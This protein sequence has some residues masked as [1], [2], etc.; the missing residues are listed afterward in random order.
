[1]TNDFNVSGNFNT[2]E[3]EVSV[4]KRL[5]ALN[6]VKVQSITKHKDANAG[7]V[8]V[9]LEDGTR[10]VIEVK[11][12]KFERFQ[13]YGDLG[14]DLLS[15]FQFKRPE[16]AEKWKGS[17]KSGKFINE[18]YNDIDLHS[19]FKKGKISYSKS[20]LWLFFSV[21]PENK[22]SYYSFFPGNFIKSKEFKLYLK[23]NCVFTVNNKPNTQLSSNDSFHSAVFFINHKDHYL[24]SHKFDLKKLAKKPGSNDP[25]GNSQA[26]G[27]FEREF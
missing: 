13:K 17:P 1:M 14:I 10:L 11:E 4:V 9:I 26:L 6:G 20:D 19:T 15:V 16:L 7:D 18:F 23:N 3:R 25:Q 24:D 21:N 2:T 22:I 12:E 27:G 5:F 8:L